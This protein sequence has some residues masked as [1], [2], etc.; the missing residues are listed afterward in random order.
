MAEPFQHFSNEMNGYDLGI[1]PL[2]VYDDYHPTTS[3]DPYNSRA[4]YTSSSNTYFKISDENTSVAPQNPGD[5]ICF[6]GN[7][8]TPNGV[9]ICDQSN[10]NG[11]FSVYLHD[12][13]KLY[14]LSPFTK[15]NYPMSALDNVIRHFT[16]HLCDETTV[17]STDTDGNTIEKTFPELNVESMCGWLDKYTFMFY[18]LDCPEDFSFCWQSKLY[19]S[20]T[21]YPYAVTTSHT[22]P[23][24]G[25]NQ[26]VHYSK[27]QTGVYNF[28]D[29]Y[30]GIL[31]TALIPYGISDKFSSFKD[32]IV[33]P[34][35]DTYCDGNQY[36]NSA[37]LTTKRFPANTP[38][39]LLLTTLPFE[40]DA[41]Y[42]A[43]L[44]NAVSKLQSFKMR[45][46]FAKWDKPYVPFLGNGG[47]SGTSTNG[48]DWGANVSEKFTPFTKGATNNQVY[49]GLS[50]TSYIGSSYYYP[51]KTDGRGNYYPLISSDY[52]NSTN[53][54]GYTT[55]LTSLY[56]T[57]FDYS[58]SNSNS[59]FYHFAY[60]LIMPQ[61]ETYYTGGIYREAFNNLVYGRLYYSR[62]R[63]G[64]GHF[65]YSYGA[66]SPYIFIA[67]MNNATFPFYF[68]MN[69]YNT[70]LNKTT[71]RSMGP[72]H[73]LFTTMNSYGSGI[74]V[75]D[76]SANDFFD[77][78]YSAPVR[79][80]TFITKKLTS[81]VLVGHCP[82]IQVSTNFTPEQAMDYML[83]WVYDN[84]K[85]LEA[86]KNGTMFRE[87]RL[88]KSPKEVFYRYPA[89]EF[90]EVPES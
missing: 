65:D 84:I 24:D 21:S 88:E 19:Y 17:T 76:S 90:E 39:L 54:T 49:T 45:K 27:T 41:M 29:I 20:N 16:Q 72:V 43:W 4:F 31:Y 79:G 18:V 69:V 74:F 10:Y 26:K 46:L 70:S 5:N 44:R 80:M 9:S 28:N 56:N 71:T 64:F 61:Y 53:S 1:D 66:I 23:K 47:A 30:G 8:Y 62:G 32:L 3:I 85:N 25:P 75:I 13:K 15:E 82:S 48:N 68:Q 2:T 67:S 55:N 51:F 35:A 50:T 59:Y 40:N 89:R 57:T 86:I 7:A 58:H 63:C 14:R 12:R 11:F 36:G 37:C 52:S 83:Q 73:L 87:E 34:L 77:V 81:S 22:L 38:T 42:K 78:F 60:S 6:T 33:T